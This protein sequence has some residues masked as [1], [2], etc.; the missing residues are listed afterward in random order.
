MLLLDQF[1]VNITLSAR[2]IN[3]FYGSP[4]YL[5]RVEWMTLSLHFPSPQKQQ[6]RRIEKQVGKKSIH[7]QKEQEGDHP[8]ILLAEDQDVL[9]CKV[10]HVAHL[11]PRRDQRF[12]FPLS[13]LYPARYASPDLSDELSLVVR[14]LTLVGFVGPLVIHLTRPEAAVDLFPHHELHGGLR[15]QQQV[16]E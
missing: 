2:N 13:D 10:Q 8:E 14:N 11:V 9:P 7:L 1:A 12:Y 6:F 16:A 5:N 3:P 4:L 15:E